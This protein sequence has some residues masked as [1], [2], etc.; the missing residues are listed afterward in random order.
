MNLESGAFGD[1]ASLETLILFWSKMEMLHYPGA[2]ETKRYLLD[3]KKQQQMMA[4]QQMAAQQE[5]M[6]GVMRQVDAQ[7]RADA[8]AAVQKQ[9]Q[10]EA[11]AAQAKARAEPQN[12]PAGLFQ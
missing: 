1:P 12:D 10:D 5:Q 8:E 4:E 6:N 7:A 2:G 11:A 9:A 3:M